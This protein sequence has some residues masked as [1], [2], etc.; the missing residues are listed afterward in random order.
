LKERVVIIGGGPAGLLTSYHLK[1]FG[2][3]SIILEKG[4]AG[5]SWR[6]MRDGMVMLSPSVPSMDMTS[7]SFDHPIWSL[8]KLKGPFATKEE[9]IEYLELFAEINKINLMKDK[10]VSQINK[11]DDGFEASVD[12]GS[13]ISSTTV[14]VA[15]GVIGHPCLPDIPGVEDNPKVIHSQNY[16]G[17]EAYR[18]KRVL[19][20]GAGNSGAE[21]TIEL[22]GVADVTLVNKDRLKYYSETGNL[23]NIRGLSESILKELINFKIIVLKEG[24][25]IESISGGNVVFSD[26]VEDEFD[27]IVFATGYLPYMPG[28]TNMEVKI[29]KDGYPEL[30]PSCESVSTKGLY[31]TG[32]LSVKSRLCSFIHCFRPK[33]APMALDIADKLGR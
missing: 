5:E 20:V 17:L 18:G 23:S 33:V 12:D 15:T 16:R 19:I 28:F 6:K 31:F 11:T 26:G 32:P 10:A 14:V 2:V 13:K 9:F 3:N 30:T 8:V 27:E 21:L 22:S 1:N 29:L 25:S 24:V 7:L 4:R